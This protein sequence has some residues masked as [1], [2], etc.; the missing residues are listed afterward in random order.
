MHCVQLR[1]LHNFKKIIKR[2]RRVWVKILCCKLSATRTWKEKYVTKI[3][4]DNINNRIVSKY[5]TNHNIKLSTNIRRERSFRFCSFLKIGGVLLSPPRPIIHHFRGHFIS[6]FINGGIIITRPLG[7][8]VIFLFTVL[9]T[10]T[11]S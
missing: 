6:L 2:S 1:Y 3:F 10:H 7:L 5:V 9:D 8:S 11:K 4:V